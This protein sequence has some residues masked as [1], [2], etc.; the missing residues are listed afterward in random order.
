MLASIDWLKQYVDIDVTPEE[1][2]EILMSLL[3]S[4]LKN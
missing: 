1:L 4:W 3:R 2:A